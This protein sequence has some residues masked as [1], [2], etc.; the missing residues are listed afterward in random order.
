MPGGA[1]EAL[2]SKRAKEPAD[3]PTAACLQYYH[4]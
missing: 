2:T 4:L 1:G 3:A